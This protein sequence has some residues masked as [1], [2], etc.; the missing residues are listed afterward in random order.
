M[1]TPEL[2]GPLLR[3]GKVEPGSV[4]NARRPGPGSRADKSKCYSILSPSGM[5]PPGQWPVAPN[6]SSPEEREPLSVLSSGVSATSP[7]V[8]TLGRDPNAIM[9]WW[10][11]LALAALP[12]QCLSSLLTEGLPHD[13]GRQPLGLQMLPGP[14][15]CGRADPGWGLPP[16]SAKLGLPGVCREHCVRRC[17]QVSALGMSAGDGGIQLGDPVRWPPATGVQMRLPPLS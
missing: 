10:A 8:R 13:H 17:E 9:E 14:H 12:A 16:R 7:R 2:P 11:P 5:P 15:N 4:P 6:S 1:E 3:E